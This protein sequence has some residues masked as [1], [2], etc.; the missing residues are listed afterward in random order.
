[1]QENTPSLK[2]QSE[3]I[4]A[5]KDN[6][7]A[8]L[9]E[10]YRNNYPKVEKLV[11]NNNGSLEQAKD[12]FQEAFIAMW[13]NL[14]TEKFIPQNASAIE[15]YLYQIAK[16][17]W[18]D[19]LRSA[20]HKKTV[21]M[22]Q[23]STIIADKTEQSIDGK[24]EKLEKAKRAFA[25]LKGGCKELLTQFYYEKKALKEIA[26]ALQLD[27]AS[28]RNKKYRCMQKLR[29]LALQKWPNKETL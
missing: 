7:E 11:L 22:D 6:D 19:Y 20:H 8:T 24:E 13:K 21:S 27:P 9:K 23:Y 17:K 15:G 10:L 16:N 2:L 3:I 1:M 28:V 14:K 29:A 18:L 5:I 25:N 4:D 12:I 26:D